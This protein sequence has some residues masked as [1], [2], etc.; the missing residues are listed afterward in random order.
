MPISIENYK[1]ETCKRCAGTGKD[2]FVSESACYG[3]RG[4]GTV[5]VLQPPSPCATCSG[6]GDDS[7]QNPPIC[8]V[9]RGVGWSHLLPPN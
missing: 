7:S 1:P 8:F 9:C 5:A 2:R 4:A 3:C 6:T